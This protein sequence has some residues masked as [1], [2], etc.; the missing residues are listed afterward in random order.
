MN[1]NECIC[2]VMPGIWRIRLGSPEKATPVSLRGQPAMEEAIEKLKQRNLP[3][4]M[5]DM[6]IR[7]MAEI[8]D[9]M[10]VT[11]YPCMSNEAVD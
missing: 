5:D 6:D 8:L 9:L 10:V 4:A 3:F 2:M 7:D 11:A 1:Y